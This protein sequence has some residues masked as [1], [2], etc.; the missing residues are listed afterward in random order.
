[1]K[2]PPKPRSTFGRASLT[3]KDLPPTSL[4]LSAVIALV[5]PAAS[6][7]STNPKPLDRPV[8]RSVMMLTRST[9]PWFSNR[10]RTESSVA[11]K[12]RFPTKRSE[13]HT[14]ELQSPYDLVCCLLL[15]KKKKA[16]STAI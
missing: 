11:P 12:L 13:E 9:V 5:A 1:R 3:V 6:V 14:S 2:P 8:S 15:E 16:L 4:P 10:E 7:I